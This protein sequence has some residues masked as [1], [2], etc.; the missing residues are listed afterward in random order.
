MWSVVIE[1]PNSAMTR[2]ARTPGSALFRRLQREARRRTAARRCRCSGARCRPGRPR[3]GCAPTAGPARWQCARSSPGRPCRASRPSSAHG[4]R[5]WRARCRPG[6]PA[7]RPGA[8]ARPVRSS[9]LA[10]RCRRW[11][12]P[13]PAGGLARK[14]A[15]SRGWMRASKL[16]LPESTPRRPGRSRCDGLADVRPEVPLH[17]RCRW[18]S[19]SRPGRNPVSPGLRQQAGSGQVLGD[20][21]RTGR[22]RGLDVRLHLQPGPSTAF[23]ASSPAASITLGLLVL[24]QLVM[25]AIST[26]PL[27][28]VSFFSVQAARVG[29]S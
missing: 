2:A 3:H 23:F 29:R 18:C 11:H 22:E 26:S 6:T 12:R 21:P 17:C 24:V 8:E 5:R 13:P 1:S 25:A 20:D 27:P 14:L 10:A 19:H 9:G 7:A 4:S 28:M 16:R 15:L